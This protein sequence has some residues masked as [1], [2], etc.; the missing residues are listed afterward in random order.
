MHENKGRVAKFS[1]LNGRNQLNSGS[2]S[3]HFEMQEALA[4]STLMVAGLVQ[5]VSYMVPVSEI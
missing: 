4:C 2:I 1:E 3:T 5:D